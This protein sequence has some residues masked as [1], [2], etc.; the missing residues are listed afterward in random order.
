MLAATDVLDRLFST[1]NVLL[2]AARDVG[3]AA[4]DGLPFLKRA[5]MRAAMGA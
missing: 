2:R 1:D 5:F 4:V 3:I